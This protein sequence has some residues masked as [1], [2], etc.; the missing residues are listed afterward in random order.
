MAVAVIETG[1]LAASEAITEAVVDCHN[2]CHI[3][4]IMDA[5]MTL[6]FASILLIL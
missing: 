2:G 5:V 6:E 4:L 3:V 1:S